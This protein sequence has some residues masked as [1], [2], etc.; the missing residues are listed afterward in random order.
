[1]QARISMRSIH[2]K[3]AF[4]KEDL[5]AKFGQA[6]TLR[7][8]RV[9][10]PGTIELQR[11]DAADD[12]MTVIQETPGRVPNDNQQL[13]GY[14]FHIKAAAQRIEQI[15]GE[16]D[17]TGEAYT[18]AQRALSIVGQLCHWLEQQGDDRAEIM[19]GLEGEGGAEGMTGWADDAGCI[20]DLCGKVLLVMGAV[21][22]VIV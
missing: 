14:V 12:Y 1:M 2:N 20:A 7:G 4:S 21:Q 13:T 15:Q 3:R 10:Q 5:L 11:H 16:G 22:E 19:K 8:F 17:F 6:L 18:V 9:D